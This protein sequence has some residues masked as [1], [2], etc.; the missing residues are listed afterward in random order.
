VSV[1]Q[2]DAVTLKWTYFVR[3]TDGP[4]GE[5][6]QDNPTSTGESHLLWPYSRIRLEHFAVW[7]II[8]F[9][10][11]PESPPKLSSFVPSPYITRGRQPCNLVC[12][13]LALLGTCGI[14]YA[15]QV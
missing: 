8:Y 4:D 5:T 15:E 10:S 13:K 9:A 7:E 11:I 14:S 1:S 2:G 6:A 3:L 12:R